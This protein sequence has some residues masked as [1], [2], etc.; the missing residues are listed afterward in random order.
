MLHR[1]ARRGGNLTMRALLA[2]F[3]LPGHLTPFLALGQALRRRKHEVWLYTEASSEAAVKAAGCS[4]LISPT[5]GAARLGQDQV[6]QP[7]MVSWAEAVATRT[8]VHLAATLQSQPVD[9]LVVD[10]M[11][12]GAVLVA[13]ASGTPW[14][15]VPTSPALRNPQF[16]DWPS[17]IPTEALRAALGLSVDA[18][19]SLQQGL[20]PQR[21]LLPW[22]AEFD[23]GQP[24]PGDAHVGPL[25]WDA[26]SDEESAFE[27]LV[28]IST[29]P[30][31][32]VRTAVLQFLQQA[33]AALEELPYRALLTVGDLVLPPRVLPGHVEVRR[34][35]EH[36]PLM[37]GLRLFVHHG[38]W[39]SIG[40][41]LRQGM[42]MLIVPF[43]R[44]QPVNAFW[45]ERL[46]LASVLPPQSSG[47]AIR[48]HMRAVLDPASPQRRAVQA[49]RARY[50]DV[51]PAEL[52][53][54]H[55]ER[56]V[57]TP[58]ATPA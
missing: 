31:A 42:P 2:P 51:A 1:I 32:Q 11:N 34:H 28:S 52:A 12:L 30:Q 9:V 44:D 47:E 14:V 4:V 20:S 23:L 33:L 21:A 3:P 6:T 29:S 27:V 18:R 19:S 56:L 25:V 58:G 36:G 39:G 38:G 43:E 45:C 50:A 57:E 8:V 22:T 13:Q 41:C 37:K 15:S 53:C 17:M 26:P 46:G 7:D 35:V 10:E 48:H 55:L 49:H 5:E 40:R 24:A 54:A 16:H